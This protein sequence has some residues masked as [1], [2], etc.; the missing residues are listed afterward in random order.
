MDHFHNSPKLLFL[1]QGSLSHGVNHFNLHCGVAASDL[2]SAACVSFQ[3]LGF[4]SRALS[5]GSLA[6][7]P[8]MFFILAFPIYFGVEKKTKNKIGVTYSVT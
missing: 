2:V 1:P 6:G 4:T 8:L 3:D 5:L 7:W